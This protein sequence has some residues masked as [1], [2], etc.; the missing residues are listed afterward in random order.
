MTPCRER[1]RFQKGRESS[2]KGIKTKSKGGRGRLVIWKDRTEDKW[3]AVTSYL[4]NPLL[5]MISAWQSLTV[6]PLRLSS[7]PLTQRFPEEKNKQ[8][9]IYFISKGWD[10]NHSKRLVIFSRV[11]THTRQVPVPRL[12]T[13]PS[14]SPLFMTMVARIFLPRRLCCMRV[15]RALKRWWLNMAIWSWI[16]PPLSGS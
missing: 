9:Y 12:T 1:G 14:P 11:P 16:V 15:V 4:I 5:E 3:A 2:Y 6:S 7:S 8:K 10:K 13:V